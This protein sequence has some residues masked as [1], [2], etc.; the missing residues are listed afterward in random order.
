MRSGSTY[1]RSYFT[2]HPDIRWTRKAWFFQLEKSDEIRQQKY[3]DFFSSEFLHRCFIDMYEGLSLGYILSDPPRK[4]YSDQQFSEWSPKWM[5]PG[6]QMDGRELIPGHD[7]LA[8][9]IKQILPESK[10]LVVLRNQVDWLRSMYL[11]LYGHLPKERKNFTD[12]L[13]TLEGKCAI[14]AGNFDK[15]LEIYE[16]FFGKENIHVMLLE[17]FSQNEEQTLRELCNFMEV[18]FYPIDRKSADKNIGKAHNQT[19]FLRFQSIL[20]TRGL[21]LATLFS[22][23]RL[24]RHLSK[25]VLTEHEKEMIRSFYAVSNYRTSLWLDCDLAKWGYPV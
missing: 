14:S 1:L 24:G 7:E 12:F 15:T 19:R 8:R 5:I 3:L 16:S 23:G 6:M 22:A 4:D 20:G 9:R 25:D 10:I 2:Q 17:E 18:P 11:H 21:K 13:D